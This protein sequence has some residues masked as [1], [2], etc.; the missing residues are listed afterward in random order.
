MSVIVQSQSPRVPSS[1]AGAADVK[2]NFGAVPAHPAAA[3][4]EVVT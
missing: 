1:T 4:E 2:P 3:F